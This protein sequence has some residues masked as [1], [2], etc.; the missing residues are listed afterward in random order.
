MIADDV[1]KGGVNFPNLL[2]EKSD[3][4]KLGILSCNDNVS[5]DDA[6]WI[7]LTSG[8][9]GKPKYCPLSH[10]CFIHMAKASQMRIGLPK[11]SIMFN[12]RPMSWMGGVGSFAIALAA[13]TTIVTIDAKQTVQN[14]GPETFLQI[15]QEEKV[16]YTV[17]MPYLMYDIMNMETAKRASYN[18]SKLKSVMT[19]GQRIDPNLIENIK[20]MLGVGIVIGYGLTE[21]GFISSIF[22]I[23]DFTKQHLTVGYGSPNVEISIRDKDNK[24]LP[25]NTQG[26][27]CTR[28]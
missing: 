14:S 19:G 24:I 5:M 7:N 21:G 16:T 1:P 13:E 20:K 15:I 4:E 12:D 2:K 6:V 25:I 9:T 23:A 3:K 11:G 22:P 18:M 8:S 27:I 17:L 28:G 26:E 10:R